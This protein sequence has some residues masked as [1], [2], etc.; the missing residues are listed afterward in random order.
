MFEER[1]VMPANLLDV[2]ANLD[3]DEGIR[4]HDST[5]CVTFVTRIASEFCLNICKGSNEKWVYASTAEEAYNMLK[6][7]LKEP[8]QIWLY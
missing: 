6:K 4:I 3:L 5:D 1:E 2:L 8:F 7:H